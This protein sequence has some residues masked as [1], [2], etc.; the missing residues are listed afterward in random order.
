MRKKVLVLLEVEVIYVSLVNL[1]GYH[2]RLVN[3]IKREHNIRVI[4]GGR[5]FIQGG[6]K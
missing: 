3:K 5:N 6:H 1:T 4:Q 2:Q